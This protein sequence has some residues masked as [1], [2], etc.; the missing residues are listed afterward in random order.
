MAEKMDPNDIV[1][2]KELLVSNSIQVD[3]LVLL[4]IEKGFITE[5]EFFSKLKQVQ[6][7]YNTTTKR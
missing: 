3:A 2:F 6:M 7:G 5:D 1:S 4:L